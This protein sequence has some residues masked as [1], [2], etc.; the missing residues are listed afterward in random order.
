MNTSR[1]PSEQQVEALQEESQTTL[2]QIKA[3][4]NIMTSRYI[5][6]DEAAQ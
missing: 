6:V 5:R 4:N 1:A 2:E 3:M